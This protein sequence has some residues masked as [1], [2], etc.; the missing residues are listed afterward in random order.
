MPLLDL[1]SALRICLA[2]TNYYR[3]ISEIKE[4]IPKCR[5]GQ[6]G[7]V[8]GHRDCYK[9]AG[10][11]YVLLRNRNK[12]SPP[13]TSCPTHTPHRS[14]LMEEPKCCA[15]SL[16]AFPPMESLQ[17]KITC[18]WGERDASVLLCPLLLLVG[19]ALVP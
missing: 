6:E 13:I 5:A 16:C 18:L 3:L 11:L 17:H 19:W 2:Y 12:S 15:V 10:Q 9:K 4:E 7:N 14:A 8:C 1:L